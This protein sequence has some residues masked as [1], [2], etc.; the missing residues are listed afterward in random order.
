MILPGLYLSQT[1]LLNRISGGK[2]CGNFYFF[3]R[4]F[5]ADFFADLDEGGGGVLSIFRNPSSKFNPC[6]E[7]VFAAPMKPFNHK[8]TKLPRFS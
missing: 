7:M 5:L 8:T 6:V 4:G 2:T 1:Q 3:R